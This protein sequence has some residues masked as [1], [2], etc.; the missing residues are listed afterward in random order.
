MLEQLKA[1]KFT[2]QRRNVAKF[3]DPSLDLRQLA[4]KNLLK[5]KASLTRLY[6][7]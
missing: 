7:R 1:R 2:L 3:L 6:V 4:G 5:R